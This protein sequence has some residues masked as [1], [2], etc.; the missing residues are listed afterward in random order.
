MA[1][2][3]VSIKSG[4]SSSYID[5]PTPSTYKV[6]SSTIVDSARDSSGKLNANVIR[7]SMRKV[8]LS[9]LYLDLI[10]F[11]NIAKL[12]DEDYGGSFSFS[13]R[14]FDPTAN[15][16]LTKEMYVGDRVTDTAKITL[17]SVTGKPI[18]YTD[19]SLSLIEV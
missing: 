8:E 1:N 16:W 17:D 15:A 6:I 14:F 3:L 18:G 7:N 10:D 9:W 4:T 11:S 2:K 5:L 13:C 12:F 19:I